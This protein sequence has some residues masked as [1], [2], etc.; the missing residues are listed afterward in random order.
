MLKYEVM[1]EE[2]G[3][4]NGPQDLVMASLCIQIVIDK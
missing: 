2:E 3:H 4:D 1:A